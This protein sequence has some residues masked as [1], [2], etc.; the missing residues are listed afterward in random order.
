MERKPFPWVFED[1]LLA[2][3]P[4]SIVGD[5]HE[6]IPAHFERMQLSS[7]LRSAF[8]DGASAMSVPVRVTVERGRITIE[9][10]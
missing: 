9:A 10:L 6:F 2:S 1:T 3:A 7:T 4:R 8:G 5:S